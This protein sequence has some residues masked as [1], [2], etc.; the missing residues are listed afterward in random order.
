[1]SSLFKNNNVSNNFNFVNENSCNVNN[2]FDQFLTFDEI[3]SLLSELFTKLSSCQNR[4]QQI[5]LVIQLGTKYF[6]NH[7]G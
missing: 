1:M 4:Q 6:Y 7:S 5:S 3:S 2:N